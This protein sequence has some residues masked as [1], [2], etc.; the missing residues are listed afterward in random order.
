MHVIHDAAFGPQRFNPGVDAAGKL[1][2]PTR[3]APT[4]S[5]KGRVMPY[6]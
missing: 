1:R 6:L 5:A 2:K 3:F 4:R